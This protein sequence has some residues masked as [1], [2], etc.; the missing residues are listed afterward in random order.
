MPLGI[1]ALDHLLGGGLPIGALSEVSGPEGSGRTSVALALLAGA[2]FEGACA[3]IDPGDTLSPESAAAAGVCLRNL[4]WVRFP[5]HS[6]TRQEPPPASRRALPLIEHPPQHG[7][8]GPHPRME[9]KNLAP[10]LEQMLFHKEE[11]RRR[12]MEGTPG[13][14]NQSFGLAS[15]SPDQIE[16]ERFN[17]R[18][19]DEADPLRIRDRQAA[20]AARDRASR[21]PS[22]I[23]ARSHLRPD[24]NRLEHAVRAADQVLQS[25]GFR[26][27]VLDLASTAPD[28]ALRIPL[29]TWFRF[30]RA[31]QES[32]VILLVLSQIAC[33]RS[34][35]ACSLECSPGKLPNLTSTLAETALQVEVA[36][37][38]AQPSIQPIQPGF[39]KKPPQ[40]A[41]A[42]TAAPSWMR[43]VGR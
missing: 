35:A 3:W 19:V 27:V 18:K 22:Q 39:G 42:W 5:A 16:W 37:Q 24:E 4:L 13:F 7:G 10:A 6:H 23:Q 15:A 31:A 28:Q 33:V 9:T 36:R 30:R 32:D 8:C 14:P 17:T 29:A 1:D 38:R 43:A 41:T 26:V 11:R 2:S 20:E 25:G 21:Q 40:R 34:S 12:K